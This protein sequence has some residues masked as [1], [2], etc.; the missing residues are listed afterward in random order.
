M[1]VG[2]ARAFRGLAIF[3]VIFVALLALKDRGMPDFT[4]LAWFAVVLGAS[5]DL[6]WKGWRARNRAV[7]SRGPGGWG[8]VM[9]PRLSRWMTGEDD[10]ER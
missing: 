4:G 3:V 8:A 5:V 7:E 9:P 1:K 6:I 10:A 2:T